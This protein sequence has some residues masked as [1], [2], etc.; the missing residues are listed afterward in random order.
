S[1]NWRLSTTAK[2]ASGNWVLGESE[3]IVSLDEKQMIGKGQSPTHKPY[4]WS[5]SREKNQW[6]DRYSESF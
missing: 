4:W 1:E 5:F 2:V 3:G 6:G